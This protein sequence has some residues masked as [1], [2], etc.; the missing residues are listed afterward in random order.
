MEDNSKLY[1]TQI[2]E[3][4]AHH[5]DSLEKMHK[6]LQSTITYTVEDNSKII[7]EF[8]NK[9]N[10]KIDQLAEILNTISNN[11]KSDSKGLF[12]RIF[13]SDQKK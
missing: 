10:E 11:I 12:E 3:S 5:D 4:I 13:S 7:T 2:S 9:Q 8:V 1:S 6:N